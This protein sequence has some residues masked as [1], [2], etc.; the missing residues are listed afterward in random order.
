MLYRVPVKVLEPMDSP[1]IR[2]CPGCG[3]VAQPIPEN[4][5]HIVI[6]CDSCGFRASIAQLSNAELLANVYPLPSI[7][8]TA[9]KISSR[10]LLRK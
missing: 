3:R 2:N 7:Q 9:K 5:K 6:S 4:R 8:E 10:Q 1:K